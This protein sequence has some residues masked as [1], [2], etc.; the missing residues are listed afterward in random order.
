[1]NAQNLMLSFLLTEALC[2]FTGAA[3]ATAK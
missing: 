1:M 2:A 3:K